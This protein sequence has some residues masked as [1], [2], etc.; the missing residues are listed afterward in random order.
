MR[1]IAL[2]VA[3]VALLSFGAL[4]A[5]ASLPV[6]TGTG[7]ALPVRARV[8]APVQQL[9]FYVGR[10][11]VPA[12]GVDEVV[13]EGVSL[14]VIDLGV[15]RWAGT[16][17]PGGVGNLVLAGHR[18]THTSP[19]EDLDQ[20]APGDLIHVTGLDG[21][22]VSYE[23]SETLIVTPEDIWVVEQTPDPILTLFAC[24][25]KGSYRQRIVVRADLMSTPALA[26]P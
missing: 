2:P 15:A 14:D 18:S 10:V 22:R 13:R 16:A 7:L 8:D 19:F 24:H 17:R 3:L 25:P 6:D 5:G 4:P 9:G 21:T 20:L 26:F 12:I 11:E 1:E 23:V